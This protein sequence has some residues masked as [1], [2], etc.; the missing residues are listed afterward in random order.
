MLETIRAY[1]AEK[2]DASGEGDRIRAEHCRWFWHLAETAERE[3]RQ[4]NQGEW[5]HQLE[6]EHDNLRA[7]MSFAAASDAELGL[8]IA[9]A[10]ARFWSLQGRGELSEGREWLERLLRSAADPPSALRAQA[11]YV[12]SLLAADQADFDGAERLARDG[13]ALF[14]DLGDD[15]GAADAAV[16]LAR[17]K[18]S[19]GDFE[20]AADLLEKGLS[21]YRRVGDRQHL[22]AV[23]NNLGLTQMRRGRFQE[24]R[25]LFEESLVLKRELGDDLGVA[26]TLHNL[27]VLAAREGDGNAAARLQNESLAIARRL[28]NQRL[29]ASAL[30]ELGRVRLT[31]GDDTSARARLTEALQLAHDVG[32]KPRTAECLEAVAGVIAATSL[33]R[34][35]TRLCAAAEVLRE[36]SGT[37]LPPDQQDSHSRVISQLQRRLSADTFDAAW[38]EGRTMPA[39]EVIDL[40]LALAA[41]LAEPSSGEAPSPPAGAPYPAGL[42]AR[43]VEV[44]RLVALGKSNQQIA[45]E[46]VISMNTVIRHVSNILRKTDANNRAEAAVFAT[47]HGLV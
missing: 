5:L 10:L 22:N 11:L 34:D 44:L 36:L 30:I 1:A 13:E 25:G 37:P 14:K 2:L 24:A 43:E 6:R 17:I 12:S 18:S 39:S 35:T 28:G 32:D 29:M 7:A 9:T 8:K 19:R 41:G 47:R 26:G 40:A 20:A 21:T 46:L 45:D 38:A 42:S 31:E 33:S 27:G 3:L 15:L 16:M 23:L 4:A